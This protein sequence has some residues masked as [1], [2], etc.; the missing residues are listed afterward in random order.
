[1][2]TKIYRTILPLKIR[3]IIYTLFLGKLLIFKRTLSENI[4]S[5]LTFYFKWLLPNTEKNEVYAFMGK[6]GRTAYPYPFSLKYKKLKIEIHHDTQLSLPYVIHNSKKL[7][8]PSS[9]SIKKITQNYK[10]LITE[11]DIES[12]HRY[13]PSFENLKGKTLLDIGAAEGIFTLDTIEYTNK[14]YLFECE[15]EW[16]PAL[17]AT[18][19]PWINKII[20][21]KKYVSDQCDNNCITIDSIHQDL[22][23]SLLFLK[24]DIE[25]AELKALKGASNTLATQNVELAVCTYHTKDD[26]QNISNF[27]AL[28]G[29]KYEFTKGLIFWRKQLNKGII[30]AYRSTH[31]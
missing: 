4:I 13:V 20:I 14:A 27:L 22:S 1:M 25:G 9:Y 16:I 30:R 15:E 11:Q 28:L 17:N 29:Y 26:A 3:T 10:N 23:E 31:E 19:A 8:F 7:Y 24:M 12:P 5:K 6:Y 2:I 18:F 21:I